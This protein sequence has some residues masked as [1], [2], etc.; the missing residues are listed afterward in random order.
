MALTL[1]AKQPQI[2]CNIWQSMHACLFCA[3]LP[4]IDTLLF[5]LAL[6][7]LPAVQALECLQVC[8]ATRGLGKAP[9]LYMQYRHCYMHGCRTMHV[10]AMNVPDNMYQSPACLGAGSLFY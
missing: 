8:C 5:G 9:G 3:S 4:P 7:P 10:Q 2:T 1:A 6:P